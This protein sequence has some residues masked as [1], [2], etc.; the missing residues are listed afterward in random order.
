[1]DSMRLSVAYVFS[2]APLPRIVNC[3]VYHT[4]DQWWSRAG[5]SFIAN[6]HLYGWKVPLLSMVE[7]PAGGVR[8]TFYYILHI[9]D[10]VLMRWPDMVDMAIRDT[11]EIVGQWTFFE[12]NA[13]NEVIIILWQL[14]LPV[15]SVLTF[16]SF[17]CMASLYR[18]WTELWYWTV[19]F[20]KT[21]K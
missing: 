13:A 9:A 16:F 17:I 14:R 20:Y 18:W 1:M 7:A 15:T 21:A 10:A 19:C 2:T 11:K 6:R 4:A 12:V 5:P 3:V 8:G